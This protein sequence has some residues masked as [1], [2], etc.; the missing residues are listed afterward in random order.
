MRI[1]FPIV[2]AFAFLLSACSGA[3]H[4][5]LKRADA[6]MEE[7]PDS[8]LSILLAIDNTGIGSQD[9]PY[10]ALLMTQA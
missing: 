6:L 8:A 4:N 7:H 10:Y 1:L 3:D 5:V 2:I 9:L